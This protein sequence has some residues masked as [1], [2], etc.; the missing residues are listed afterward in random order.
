IRSGLLADI[1]EQWLHEIVRKH[2]RAWS[3]A[4]AG[5]FRPFATQQR[6]AL[7]DTIAAAMVFEGLD[8]LRHA[9]D[10]VI[11]LMELEEN[12]P[13][14]KDGDGKGLWTDDPVYQPSRRV[15]EKLM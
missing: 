12:L 6:E 13:G 15:I 9:Q 5:T 7:S 10:V 11:W 4:E 1:D 14:F 8:R 2:Y 3:Y